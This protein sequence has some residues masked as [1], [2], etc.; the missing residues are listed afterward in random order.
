MYFN[1]K[2]FECLSLTKN[3]KSN[4]NYDVIHSTQIVSHI[5][6]LKLFSANLKTKQTTISCRSNKSNTRGAK[7][8]MKC[9]KVEK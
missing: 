1:K 4:S 8:S 5:E 9:K 2:S 6:K 3:Q 7:E